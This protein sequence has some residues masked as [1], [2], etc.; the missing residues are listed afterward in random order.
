[1]P[2]YCP[3]PRVSLI[4]KSFTACLLLWCASSGFAQQSKPLDFVHDVVPILK[5]HCTPCHGGDKAEGDFSIN[6]RASLLRADVVVLGDADKSRLF[7]LVRSS[8]LEDQMPPQGK[9]RL[10]QNEIAILKSWIDQGLKWHSEF[11]FA[12]LSYEPELKPRRPKLPPS[13]NGNTNPIDR[14]VSHYMV[15]RKI[16]FPTPLDDPAFL[17]RVHFDLIGLPPTPSELQSF[18]DDKDPHKRQKHIR[19]LL[20]RNQP[21]AEHWMTFWN[22]LLRNAYAGT[23]YIDGGRKQITGWLY[24]SLLENKPYDIFVRE[25]IAPT[26][27]AEG[28]IRGIK[29]RGNVNASQSPE[30]QFAQSISQVMLGINMKCASCHDSFIDRWTLKEAYG[31]A[32]IFADKPLQMFRCDK[33]T[34]QIAKAAWI[35][36]ELGTIDGNA[37]QPQRLEQLA[38]LMTHPENG[39]LTR[40]IVNR[41]WQQMMGRGIVHPVDAMH[42]RPWNEDLLDYLAVYLVEQDY[43]MKRVLELIA[44]SRTYQS[45]IAIMAEVQHGEEYI[46][47][48]P[49]IKRMSA[50]QFMDSIWATTESWP[51]PSGRAVKNDGR[52]QGGQLAAVLGAHPQTKVWGDR[53]LR[54]VFTFIDPLQASLGRPNREQVVTT[55]PQTMTTLEAI[56]LANGPILAGH[57]NRAATSLQKRHENEDEFIQW[58]YRY[59]L[60]RSPTTEELAVAKQF[61]T[62]ESG[63]LGTED[64]LW[65]VF[66]LPEFQFIR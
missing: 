12:K 10:A 40:T 11:S 59:S 17:R 7:E 1:M 25:L 44:S 14:I 37:K 23:G 31:L 33:P 35:F 20:D 39:R 48:G 46:F 6:T 54:A 56:H 52:S 50:E 32:A 28:F 60:S 55:R 16:A 34:G 42:T 57:L 8:D 65:T 61:L 49:L 22:D 9:P 29:W 58:F 51:K 15:E 5:K 53:P 64:F 24:Q 66:M 18:L 4:F 63:T 13:R 38:K 30:V 27:E 19:H 43:D 47:R 2:L 36:P 62:G 3:Y 26:A 21:Y 45:Q 41:L